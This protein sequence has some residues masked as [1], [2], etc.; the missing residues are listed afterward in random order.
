MS[1]LLLP[2]LKLLEASI[3]QDDPTGLYGVKDIPTFRRRINGI[4]AALWRDEITQPEF[5]IGMSTLIRQQLTEA[6]LAGAKRCG[7][8]SDEISPEAQT[9][10]DSFVNQNI[11][12]LPG[13]AQSIIEGNRT[14]GALLR[15]HQARAGMWANAYNDARN[16][17]EQIACADQKLRWIWDPFKEHCSDCAAL[18]GQVRRASFWRSHNI[19]PQSRALECRG[20]NC[21]CRFAVSEMALSRGRLPGRF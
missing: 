13:F 18:N 7:V 8:R 16:R 19:H 11:S 3:T 17:S 2:S 14:E 4:V 12:F 5:V 6:W 1:D 9:E 20:F 15:S 21:G 10:L